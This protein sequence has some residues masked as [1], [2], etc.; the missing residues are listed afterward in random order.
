[1]SKVTEERE[2]KHII[3]NKYETKIGRQKELLLGSNYH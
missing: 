3:K 2:V 1:M